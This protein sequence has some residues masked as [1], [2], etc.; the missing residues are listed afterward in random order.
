MKKALVLVV[1]VTLLFSLAACSSDGNVTQSI[2]ADSTS[3]QQESRVTDNKNEIAQQVYAVISEAEKVRYN[4]SNYELEL[5]SEEGNR[6]NF[7]FWADWESIREVEDDPFIQGL[8]QAAETL[9][10]EQEKAYAEEVIHDWVT[11]MQGWSETERLETQIVVM[12]DDVGTWTLYYPFVEDGKET[13]ILLEEY[14][15]TE[16]TEDSEARR[17][18]GIDTMNEA[19]RSTFNPESD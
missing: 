6:A 7:I 11:E 16:W 15:V 3:S 19:V 9:S 18:S 5:V 2:S 1:A 10:D 4:I 14:A 12:T 17:Q 8:R 13:L